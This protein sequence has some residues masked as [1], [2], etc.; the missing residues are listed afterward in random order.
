MTQGARAGGFGIRELALALASLLIALGLL[1][2]AARLLVPPVRYHDAEL[3]LDPE[4]G[5]RGV[6]DIR[7]P[8]VFRDDL[9]GLVLNADGFRGRELPRQPAAPGV[10]RIAMLGDSFLVGRQVGEEDLMT[11]RIER[12]LRARGVEAEVYNL[13]VTD[14]GTGQQLLLLGRVAE[15][16][17]PDAIVL[18]FYVGNDIANNSLRLAGQTSVSPGDPIRPYVAPEGGVL[19][20]QWMDPW[21]ARLRRSRLFAFFERRTLAGS[22]ETRETRTLPPPERLQRGLAPRAHLEVFREHGPRHPWSRAWETSFELLR[23]VRDRSEAL[24]ARFLVLVI[25]DVHQVEHSALDVRFGV[26]ALVFAGR[27][28]DRLLD[29][30][31][32]ERRLADFFASEG[33]DASF[34]LAPLREAA[35]AQPVYTTDKHLSARGHEIAA[36]RVE[37]WLESGTAAPAAPSEGGP[38]HA[39]RAHDGGRAWLD[40]RSERHDLALGFG[41]ILWRPLGRGDAGWLTGPSALVALRARPGE[42][43]VRG[44]VPPAAAL[45]VMVQLGVVGGRSVRF[46]LHEHGP[47]ELRRPWQ[48]AHRVTDANGFAAIL[49]RPGTTHVEQGY[50][51]GF[52]VTEVGF[53]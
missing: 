43:V 40:F 16:L 48:P 5:F 42:L 29:W 47:F 6:P 52:V 7:L 46:D 53:E 26:E 33:I 11:S 19:R 45:P 13:G 15:A 31:L 35:L 24:G 34:L 8:P 41:W 32:P 49:I 14:Y 4:L 38:V 36:A 3:E 12:S 51:L 21:R 20:V 23:A 17:Q 44:V 22:V 1:E 27:P 28:L 30:N 2:L 9:P 25:P 18:A 10:T 39:L 50:P 37:T